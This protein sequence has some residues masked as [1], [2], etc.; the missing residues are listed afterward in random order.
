MFEIEYSFTGW[1][2][3]ARE[4]ITRL[5]IA[6]MLAYIALV[7]GH[8]MY[9]AIAGVSSTAWDSAAEFVALAMNSSPT[10]VL[11]STCAGIIGRQAIK[12]TVRVLLTTPGHLELVF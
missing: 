6:V 9:S 1:I 11:Q 10:E 2:Y 4:T 12:T 5:A 8:I 7:F 3:S